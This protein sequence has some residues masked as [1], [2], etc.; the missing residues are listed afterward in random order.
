[1][2][3]DLSMWFYVN[4]CQG[5]AI[6]LYEISGVNIIV[7]SVEHLALSLEIYYGLFHFVR[8]KKGISWCYF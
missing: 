6:K 8:G 1:M 3:D 5:G 4:I 2:C 7:T